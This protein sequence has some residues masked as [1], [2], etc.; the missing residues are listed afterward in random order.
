MSGEEKKKYRQYKNS[1]PLDSFGV[2]LAVHEMR[3]E[4]EIRD[5]EEMMNSITSYVDL[6]LSGNGWWG[7]EGEWE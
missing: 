7:R 1:T 3:K 2:P 4:K 6:H 5:K